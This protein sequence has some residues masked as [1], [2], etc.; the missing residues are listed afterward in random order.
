MTAALH[1]KS[2]PAGG[3]GEVA[4]ARSSGEDLTTTAPAVEKR[5][6]WH[7]SD[8]ALSS[9]VLNPGMG[10]ADGITACL[11]A[12]PLL[13]RLDALFPASLCLTVRKRPDLIPPACHEHLVRLML[14]IHGAT[15]EV[16]RLLH[17][18]TDIPHN[19]PPFE[20]DE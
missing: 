5:E 7:I 1:E 2:R 3:G 10:F 15:A 6:P 14:N 4:C 11:E 16:V 19:L 20:V 9:W 12:L 8:F 17:E 18:Y 13:R